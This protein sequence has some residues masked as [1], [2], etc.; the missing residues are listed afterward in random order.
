MMK[1]KK[2]KKNDLN[3]LKFYFYKKYILF[4]GIYA[5]PIYNL[6]IFF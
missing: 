6:K 4:V 5:T 2:N 1:K 3:L